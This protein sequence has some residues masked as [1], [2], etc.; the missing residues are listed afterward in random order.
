MEREIRLK[1]L[2]IFGAAL[3]ENYTECE[4]PAAGEF[5]SGIHAP[6]RAGQDRHQP[7]KPEPVYGHC[8]GVLYLQE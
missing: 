4:D 7:E 2:G 5:Y 3:P 6:V 1:D 8:R